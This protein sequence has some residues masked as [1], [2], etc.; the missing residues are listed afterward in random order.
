MGALRETMGA[1]IVNAENA[2]WDGDALEAQAFAYLAA[3]TK[4]GL[5]ISFPK[6]TGVKQ[7]L[8]GGKYASAS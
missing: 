2:G 7:P 3:R 4:L 6:T 5:P 1:Q 8:T